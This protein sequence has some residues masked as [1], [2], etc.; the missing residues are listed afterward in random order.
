VGE[1]PVTG[2]SGGDDGSTLPLVL[3]CFLVGLLFVAGFVA[4]SSAFLAQRDLQSDCDGAAVAGAAAVDSPDLYVP[5]AGGLSPEL[6]LATDAA[7]TAVAEYAARAGLGDTSLAATVTGRA[8]V[9]VVCGRTVAV[10]FGAVFGLG[11]GVRRTAHSGA[12]SPVRP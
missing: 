2:H 12:R 10:P 7:A 5:A 9:A 11:D 4:A 6:P 8:E 1:A 3:L